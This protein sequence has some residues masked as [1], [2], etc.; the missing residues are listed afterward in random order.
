MK[1][2]NTQEV[3]WLFQFLY[4][5]RWHNVHVA[6]LLQLH[7]LQLLQLFKININLCSLVSKNNEFGKAEVIM[8]FLH[9][10]ALQ[11]LMHST[12]FS[13]PKDSQSQDKVEEEVKVLTC[14]SVKLYNLQQ[15]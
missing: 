4:D 11:F 15:Y 12:C 10:S 13:R 2:Q 8:H 9:V 7:V 3:K 5:D 14:N 1:H 6:L